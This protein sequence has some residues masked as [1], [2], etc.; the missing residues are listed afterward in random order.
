MG[1]SLGEFRVAA[2]DQPLAGKVRVGQLEQ[3]ALVKEPEL[4]GAPGQ[5][6]A[7]RL[8]TARGNPVDA[9]DLAER[10][11]LLLGDHAAVANQHEALDTERLAD[12][13]NMGQQFRR[14]A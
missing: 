5:E 2:S 10:I 9:V 8:G 11:D 7:N 12:L 6:L 3:I 4:K 14:V 13:L 1:S